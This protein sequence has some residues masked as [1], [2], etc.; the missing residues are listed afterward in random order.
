MTSPSRTQATAA[1]VVLLE[2]LVLAAYLPALSAG[3]VWDDDV[4]LIQNPLIPARNGLWKIWTQPSAIP[5][6]THYW[7]LFYTSFWLECRL[8]GFLPFGYHLT[9]VVLHLINTLLFW[10][11]L[12]RLKVPGAWIAAAVFG[13]HPVHVESVAWIVAR[14]DLLSTAF[15]FLAFLAWLRFEERGSKGSY[16]AALVLFA[17]GMLSKSIVVSLPAALAACVWWRKG[18]IDRRDAAFLA[19]FFVLALAIALADFAFSRC[20][21]A[22]SAFPLSFPDRLAIAGRALWFYA[23]KIVWPRGLVA[24]YPRWATDPRWARNLMF[25]L[26]AALVAGVLW[27]LRRRI[28]RGPFAAVFL[29]AATLGPMLGFIDFDFMRLSFVADRFQYLASASPIAL[30]A[31]GLAKG[32]ER[33][34]R[35]C[36]Q[37]VLTGTLCLVLPILGFLT[38]RQSALYRNSEALFRH[39]VEVNPEAWLAHDSLATALLR[40]GARAEAIKRYRQALNLYPENPTALNNLGSTL[41]EGGQSEEAIRCFREALRLE[42]GFAKAHFNLGRVLEAQ[43]PQGAAEAAAHYRRVLA[44][45]PTWAP[46]LERLAWILATHPDPAVRDPQRALELARKLSEG[47]RHEDPRHLDVLAAAQAAAGLFDQARETAQRA[48]ELVAGQAEQE[49]LAKALRKRIE[50]YSLGRPYREGRQNG[51]ASD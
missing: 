30:I 33:L 29:F 17:C 36:G 37:W 8:W 34:G 2:L 15:Y 19:P 1:G 31:A 4:A 21:G 44:V 51:M 25:P 35:Q 38:W 23:G 26:S 10:R 20:V 24:V 42:P 6:E 3:F 39:N 47:S 49:E 5:R 12:Q 40:R 48:L 11:L 43:S 50:S 18:R 46:A 41:A 7:P 16:A 13:L 32:A 9:N 28:G 45:D 27:G 14:K 22:P